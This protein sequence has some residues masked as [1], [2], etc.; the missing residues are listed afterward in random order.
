MKLH[1][2]IPAILAF[3]VP[4]SVAHA[5]QAGPGVRAGISSNPDQFYFGA[6]LDTGPIID[7][8][9]FRPNVEIGLGDGLTSISGNFEFVYWWPIPNR[10]WQ[11][12]AGGGPSVNVSRFDAQ[13]GN[14]TDLGPAFNIV[15]GLAHSRGLFVEVKLGL[16]HN[17]L[18]PE[19]LP[20]PL[21]AA[22]VKFGIGYTWK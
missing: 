7:R 3:F 4:V 1:I 8:L 19:D 9:S 6:H 22:E 20:E 18:H 14:R 12:Y 11:V 17:R 15:G 5:Q 16:V 13:H 21:T 10:P 2:I